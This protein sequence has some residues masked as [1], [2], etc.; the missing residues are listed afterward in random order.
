ML[1]GPFFLVPKLGLL[2]ASLVLASGFITMAV[3]SP[4]AGTVIARLGPRWVAPCGAL[5]TAVGLFS[6][7]SWQP[8]TSIGLMLLSLGLHGVG[9]GFFQVFEHFI[10]A[11]LWRSVASPAACRC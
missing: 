9:M 11:L 8:D 10:G 7:G 6:V 4:A 2:K 1:I 3:A 5:L